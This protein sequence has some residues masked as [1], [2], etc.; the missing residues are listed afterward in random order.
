MLQF[1]KQDHVARTKKFSA[2]CLRDEIDAFGGAAREHDFISTRSAD[3]V[4]HTLPRFFVMLGCPRAQRVET[5]MHIRVFMFVVIAN[6]IED[7]ARL[8]GAGGAIE[9]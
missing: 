1:G 8:L 7:K 4:G 9:V 3:K 6:D 5:A 2:P